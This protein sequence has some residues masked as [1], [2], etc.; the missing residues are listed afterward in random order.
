MTQIGANTGATNIDQAVKTFKFTFIHVKIIC[1]NIRAC[2]LQQ[3]QTGVS[4]TKIAPIQ[5]LKY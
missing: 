5:H 3:I 4:N 2:K 1:R